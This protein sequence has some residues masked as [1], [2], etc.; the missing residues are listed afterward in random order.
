MTAMEATVQALNRLLQWTSPASHRGGAG[1]ALGVHS[2]QIHPS[3]PNDTKTFLFTK[4]VTYNDYLDNLTF[5]EQLYF[6][7]S[8]F[9]GKI[10]GPTSMMKPCLESTPTA[11][12]YVA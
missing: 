12:P 6:L 5:H 10:N 1:H 9:F 11:F 7:Q 2:A 4:T 3:L 8:A